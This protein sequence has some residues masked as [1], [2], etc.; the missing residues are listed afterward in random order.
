MYKIV[1][2][3]KN[4][5]LSHNGFVVFVYPGIYAFAKWSKVISVPPKLVPH[6]IPVP[7]GLLGPC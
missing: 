1:C 7:P 6:S 2:K 4:D 5:F 3:I